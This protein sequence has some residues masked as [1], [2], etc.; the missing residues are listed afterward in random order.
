MTFT[1]SVIPSLTLL[2]S[3]RPV[4]GLVDR[5][6][7]VSRLSTDIS[8]PTL[9]GGLD[10]DIDIDIDIDPSCSDGGWDTLDEPW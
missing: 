4:A 1:A 5:L 2:S 10:I 6:W 3:S 8:S 9:A 7:K